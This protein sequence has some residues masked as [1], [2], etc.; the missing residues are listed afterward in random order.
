[1]QMPLYMPDDNLTRDPRGLPRDGKG[2]W[3]VTEEPEA[4]VSENGTHT[5]SGH[6]MFS[7]RAHHAH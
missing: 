2:I 7:F 4:M 3:N 6:L 1:M 5:Y